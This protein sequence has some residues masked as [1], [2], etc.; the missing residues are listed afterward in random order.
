LK[1]N[2]LKKSDVYSSDYL[3]LGTAPSLSRYKAFM[4]EMQ[5]MMEEDSKNG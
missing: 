3:R 2:D 1:R 4:K 5:S